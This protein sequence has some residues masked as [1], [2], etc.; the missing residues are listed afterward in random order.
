MI[1]KKRIINTLTEIEM[2]MITESEVIQ[3]KVKKAEQ[4]LEIAQQNYIANKV[5]ISY[6]GKKYEYLFLLK[7]K[8][9]DTIER[10]QK[11]LSPSQ[12]IIIQFLSPVTPKNE[13]E[14][15]AKIPFDPSTI[16][17]SLKQGTRLTCKEM[18]PQ[19]TAEQS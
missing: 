6:I 10:L 1:N 11:L 9:R 14:R 3:L 17:D 8:E 18:Y 4:A 12:L 15:L 7:R 16:E 2:D 19:W 13:I 5:P